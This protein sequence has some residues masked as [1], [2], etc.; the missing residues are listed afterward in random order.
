MLSLNAIM[1]VNSGSAGSPTWT[2][3]QTWI[4]DLKASLS[5]DKADSTTR[6]TGGVKT[7][8]PSL[9]DI[10]ISGNGMY[11][12]ADTQCAAFVAAAWARTIREYAIS[13]GPIATAGS[14][15]IRAYCGIFKLEADQQLSENQRFDFELA[16]ASPAANGTTF[17]APTIN[18]AS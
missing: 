12:P 1:A 18:I 6:G 17:A 14:V 2:G 7:Q 3:T 5:F 8:E 4:K 13:T 16:P 9:A 15:Y 10:G 11:L